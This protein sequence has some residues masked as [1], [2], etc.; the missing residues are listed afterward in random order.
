MRALLR[1]SVVTVVAFVLSSVLFLAVPV[2]NVLFFQDNLPARKS[3]EKPREVEVLVQ[4]KKQVQQQKTI[5]SIQQPNSFKAN[6]QG[7]PQSQMRGFQMD[8]SL[9][10]GDGGEG[11]AVGG[12]GMGNAVYEAG[13]V[14]EEARMLKEVPAKYPVRAQKQGISGHVKMYLVIDTRGMVS[15]MQVI[16]VDPPGYGF[17]QEAMAAMREWRFE[18]AKLNG[19]PVSQKA[20][21]EFHFVQ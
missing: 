17:E 19:F 10:L 4:P 8:L 1:W 20:T 18:P 21:K 14:D 15:E 16:S 11:V 12:G 7:S 3:G 2:L 5:R 6:F 13:E 9:A